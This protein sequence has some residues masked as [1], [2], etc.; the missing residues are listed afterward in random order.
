MAGEIS[1][2]ADGTLGRLVRWLR[3]LG[4]RTVYLPSATVS[5]LTLAARR[6]GAVALSRSAQIEKHLGPGERL[7]IRSDR[8]A[9]QL[10]DVLAAFHLEIDE[11][12]MFSLCLNCN[13]KLV[14]VRPNEV[15]DKVPAYVFQT[16]DQFE[17]CPLCGKV[18]WAGTHHDLA[19]RWLQQNGFFLPGRA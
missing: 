16:H 1:F 7:C 18:F 19:R 8:V 13:E 5:E 4:F 11:S 2:V 9:D 12:A 17:E 15:K 14:H 10:R 3:L 6:L